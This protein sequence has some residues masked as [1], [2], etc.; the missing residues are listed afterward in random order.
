MRHEEF[1]HVLQ[2]AARIV[3]DELVVVGS[4]AVLGQFPDAPEALLRS[5]EIDL[6]PRHHPDRSDDIDG[7]LGD[8]SPFHETYSYYAHAVGRE[9]AKAPA[10]WEERLV[11][12]VLPGLT[13]TDKLVTAWCLEVHDLVLSKL[14]AGRPHDM[15]FAEDAVRE[16]L[17]DVHQLRLGVD[18]M[19]P[20]LRDVV[21][22]RLE[23]VVARARR[24]GDLS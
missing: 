11:R 3:D 19:P 4:Q 22:E 14:A 17:V 20:R 15:T 18:L 10:G 24:P 16:N 7:S 8:G 5:A 21:R 9:T 1:V 13:P 2:A 23:G 12:V 6:F